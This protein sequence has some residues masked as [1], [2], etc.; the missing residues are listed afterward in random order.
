MAA[1]FSGTLRLLRYVA[2]IIAGVSPAGF[3]GKS[4]AF[5]A[6]GWLCRRAKRG[7]WR[8]I[9]ALPPLWIFLCAVHLLPDDLM[10]ESKS[11][12]RQ[13]LILYWTK[14]YDNDFNRRQHLY[15]EAVR[16][17][18][19]CPLNNCVITGNR[20]LLNQS[21]AVI[22]HVRD[23]RWDILPAYRD[24]QQYY[25]FHLLESPPHTVTSLASLAPGFFNLT[26]TYRLDSDIVANSYFQHYK[27]PMWTDW[28]SFEE[29]WRV[30]TKLAVAFVSNCIT[31]SRRNLVLEELREYIA[32]DV[33]GKCGP[34]KCNPTSTKK[35]AACN[36]LVSTYKFF[37]AFENR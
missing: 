33:Y 22:F 35:K 18:R 24:P 21:S 6:M 25:V 30:K 23:M 15:Q 2:G 1:S 10:F 16:G 9:V 11:L 4:A 36:G 17:L 27:P 26:F 13:P 12:P 28:S 32:I 31:P 20:S 3:S 19:N 14:F 29:T 5:T 7:L 8:C 37:L 34:L